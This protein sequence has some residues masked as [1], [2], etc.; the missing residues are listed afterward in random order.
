VTTFSVASETTTRIRP[1]GIRR[2]TWRVAHT[3]ESPGRWAHA[4]L[5]GSPLCGHEALGLH[6]FPAVR[7]EE[8][9]ASVR[10]DDCDVLAGRS[11]L[12]PVRR[13]PALVPFS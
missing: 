6:R 8:V 7:F 1:T 10:C 12:R 4:V 3:P 11:H 5:D 13:P 2:A 9:N